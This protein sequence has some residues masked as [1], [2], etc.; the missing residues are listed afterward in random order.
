MRGTKNEVT[1]KVK[2]EEDFLIRLPHY[3]GGSQ[4]FWPEYRYASMRVMYDDVAIVWHNGSLKICVVT[5]C[6]TE[7]EEVQL[8]VIHPSSVKKNFT[9]HITVRRKNVVALLHPKR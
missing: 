3:D 1:T 5:K 7:K 8:T 9:H 6:H 2:N 4:I